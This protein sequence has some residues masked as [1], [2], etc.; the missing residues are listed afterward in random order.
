MKPFPSIVPAAALA[1]ALTFACAAPAP[2]NATAGGPNA[3]GR[4][5]ASSR[6]V[7]YTGNGDTVYQDGHVVTPNGSSYFP[8]KRHQSIAC[9]NGSCQIHDAGRRH[10]RYRL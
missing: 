6:I 3:R 9:A 10:R 4:Q 1:L 8:R 5:A 2:A 7:G